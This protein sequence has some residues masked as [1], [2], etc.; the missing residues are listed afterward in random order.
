LRFT[1]PKGRIADAIDSRPPEVA[2]RAATCLRD[3][4]PRQ[5]CPVSADLCGSEQVIDAYF[6]N[7]FN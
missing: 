1:F 2:R 6:A 7:S 5:S 4:L 3:A